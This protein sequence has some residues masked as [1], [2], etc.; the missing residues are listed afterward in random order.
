MPIVV[1]FLGGNASLPVCRTGQLIF[2]QKL[3]IM[4][5]GVGDKN[6]ITM[7]LIFSGC[8]FVC[9]SCW[10]KQCGERGILYAVADSG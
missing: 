6:I 2:E 3:E 4:A 10:K 8:R 1:A 7:L 5:R 9:R